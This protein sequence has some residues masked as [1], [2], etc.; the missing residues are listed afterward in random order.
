MNPSMDGSM[1]LSM[2]G[3]IDKSMDGLM[4]GVMNGFMDVSYF[5]NHINNYVSVYFAQMFHIVF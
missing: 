5:T 3:L 4:D 1:Y 2:D